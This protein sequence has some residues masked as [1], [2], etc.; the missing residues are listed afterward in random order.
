M[1]RVKNI[2]VCLF[3]CMFLLIG[4]T[5]KITAFPKAGS[6]TDHKTIGNRLTAAYKQYFGSSVPYP[7]YAKG[8][9]QAMGGD[10]WTSVAYVGSFRCR[11]YL[12]A[13]GTIQPAVN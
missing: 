3:L 6:S 9:S 2:F 11:L 10:Y 5:D 13:D 1:S 4:Y 12:L 7:A 8:Q